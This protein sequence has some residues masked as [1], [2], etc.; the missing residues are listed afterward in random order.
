MTVASMVPREQL[1][2]EVA[3]VAELASAKSGRVQ[4]RQERRLS[5]PYPLFIGKDLHTIA[6][7]KV[8]QRA[9]FRVPSITLSKYSDVTILPE[10]LIL[11]D[12]QTISGDSCEEPVRADDGVWFKDEYASDFGGQR[13]CFPRLNDHKWSAGT[14]RIDYSDALGRPVQVIDAPAFSLLAWFETNVSHWLVDVFSRLWALPFIRE[15]DFK[16]LVPGGSIPYM[17]ETLELFGISPDRI[18]SVHNGVSYK[19][20]TLYNVSRLASHYNYFS[21]EIIEFYNYLPNY[22]PNF[23]L[24]VHDYVYISRRDSDKRVCENELELEDRLRERGFHIATLSSL[25]IVERIS[26]LRGAKLL[27]G[28]CGAGMAHALMME[29][30]TRLLVTGA[31]DMH[32]NS[33]LFLNIA[34]AKSQTVAL[35]AGKNLENQERTLSRWTLPLEDTLKQVDRFVALGA[36]AK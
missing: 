33:N 27:M 1:L 31:P 8:F 3:S 6:S 11:I 5:L 25:S 36:G 34:A 29:N 19:V 18:V 12:E 17:K 21:P 20:K 32:L 23:Q 28:A 15:R 26:L 4:L 16:I 13:I 9:S 10:K 14:N 35:L 22:I 24:G 2:D 30:N 7:A